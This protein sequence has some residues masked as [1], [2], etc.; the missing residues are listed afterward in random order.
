LPLKTPKGL[1]IS[2]GKVVYL[3]REGCEYLESLNISYEEMKE[4]IVF[5][6]CKQFISN[7][8]KKYNIHHKTKAERLALIDLNENQKS[9]VIKYKCDRKTIR[10]AKKIQNDNLHNRKQ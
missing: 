10:K 3:N 8:F 7:S 4:Y 5:N 1:I 9:I 2:N 6:T